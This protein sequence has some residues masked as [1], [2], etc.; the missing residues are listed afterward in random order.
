MRSVRV[1]AFRAVILCAPILLLA[2][3]EGILRLIPGTGHPPLVLTLASME[4]RAL[5]S[6][7]AIFPQRFFQQRY[8]GALVASGRMRAQPYLESDRTTR[9]RVVVVGASTVQGYPHPHRL[10]SP[11][12]LAAMLADGF[13]SHPVEVFNLGITSIASFAVARAVEAALEL[14][15][16]ALIIYSGHNEFY[17]I[18]GMSTSPWATQINYELMSW[19]LPRLIK[20]AID[21]AGGRPVSSGQLLET[22]AR[23]GQ[24]GL[25]DERRQMAVE[26][27]TTN[28]IAAVNACRQAGV[29]PILCTLAANEE[30]FAPAESA[31]P[32]SSTA[33]GRIWWQHVEAAHDRLRDGGQGAAT[34]ALQRL[35]AAAELF[36]DAAWLSFLRGRAL[37]EL[38][39]HR[40]ANLA[41]ARAR[42]LDTMPWRAPSSH[43]VAI[44]DVARSLDVDMVDVEAAFLSAAQP[45][46]P[47]WELMAD[48]VHPTVSG[49][50][51]LARALADFI[52][53]PEARKELQTDAEYLTRQ[54]HV[55]AESVGVDQ[56]MAELLAAAPMDRFNRDQ[57]QHFR[58]RAA[59]RWNRLSAAEQRGA[60]RWMSH[61]DEIPLVLDLAD[62]L[63]A[64]GYFDAALS[65][66]RAAR[67]EAPFTPRGDLWSAVQLG[68]CARM[69]GMPPAAVHDELLQALDRTR[70]VAQAPG[71]DPAFISF[72]SGSL[73][74]F[75]GEPEAALVGLE[76]AFLTEGLRQSFLFSLFP[77]LAEELVATSRLQD[78]RRY[79]TM[80][81][82]ATDGGPYFPRLVESLAANHE[83]GL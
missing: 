65:H 19:R 47:G 7:N 81:A 49:Q 56:A 21:W 6:T 45:A 79:A 4:G 37:R 74:H 38:R 75:L 41:F 72:A 59:D 44:R 12:F 34:I 13:G 26:Q 35:D 8:E 71:V 50:I 33:M 48:H 70:F 18:Y 3:A 61:R 63:Y 9:Y 2:L 53:T 15:P 69:T 42:D 68:W 17:G 31:A 32:D 16:D 82:A 54:G 5:K 80:A 62:Q 25:V 10:A 30:G 20:S 24:V 28:L 57:S 27:L 64:D 76:R 14:H 23:R 40:L 22:M 39:Q 67:L 11:A 43:N 55:P 46:R 51:L 58:Q 78:A 52:L 73:H 36:D 29:R 83:R 66:Y 77:L 60:Q 1:W